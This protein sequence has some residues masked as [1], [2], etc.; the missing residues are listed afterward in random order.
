MRR[1]PLGTSLV[2]ESTDNA[3]IALPVSVTQEAERIATS[4]GA[5]V[6]W[7]KE[8]DAHLMEVASQS[9]VAFA[10][11]SDGGFIWPDFLPAPDAM[12]TLARV[13]DLLALGGRPLS[14][15]VNGLP[16]VH[17]VHDTV[18]TPWDRKGTVMRELVEQSAG[19]RVVLVDGVKV[20]RPE[21]WALVLPDPEQAVTHVWAEAETDQAAARLAN[22]YSRAIRQALRAPA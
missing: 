13:L 12:A 2:T 19:Y 10:A 21:G 14:A 18:A 20:M 3:R 8:S 11:S 6:V 17:I 5:Q 15:V 4:Y 1:S 16:H 22:E 9:D 7:T